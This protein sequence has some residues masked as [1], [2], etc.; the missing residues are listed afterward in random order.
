RVRMA[1]WVSVRSMVSS[2]TTN[3]GTGQFDLSIFLNFFKGIAA[4]A[5]PTTGARGMR[6]GGGALLQAVEG[7]GDGLAADGFAVAFEMEDLGPGVA[8]AAL[9]AD[10]DGA[11]GL[12]LGAAVGTGDACHGHGQGGAGMDQRPGHHLNHAFAA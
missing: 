1:R 7:G 12:V 5:A 6:S 3:A 2:I 9:P 4:M 10:P 11:D 8:A